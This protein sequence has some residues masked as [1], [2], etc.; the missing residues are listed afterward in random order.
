MRLAITG[1]TGFVGATLLHLALADGHEV[2]ALTRRPQLP[3]AGLTWIDGALDRPDS[4][5]ALVDGCE[6]V[7]HVAGVVN[8]DAEAFRRGNVLG[9]EAMVAAAIAARVGRFV[10][11]SSLAAR[12]PGLSAYGRSK[13]ESELPVTGSDLDWTIVRPPAVYG[14]GDREIL[15]LFRFARRGLV[16]LPPRGRLSVIHVADLG[17]LLLACLAQPISYHHIYE[18]DDGTPGGW[19]HAGFVRA[20][21]RAMGRQVLPL[22][23]PRALLARRSRQAHRRPRRLFQPSRL[24]RRPTGTAA[25]G[26]VVPARR[27]GSRPRRHRG[28]VPR[29]GLALSLSHRLAAIAWHPRPMFSKDRRP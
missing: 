13:R 11:V 10:H 24:D 18:P 6:A 4:L 27:H 5:R 21:G 14:P 19:S 2:R 29:A 22:P 8:G 15:E 28:L 20:L 7:I 23:L 16:P 25:R 1:G 9:T 3:R 26:G 12:E 17:R